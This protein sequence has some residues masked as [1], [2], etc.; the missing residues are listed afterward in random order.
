MAGGVRR[1][2]CS[3]LR[4]AAYCALRTV[5]EDGVGGGGDSG[6]DSEGVRRDR[7]KAGA[8]DY[9]WWTRRDNNTTWKEDRA[10]R[11]C[12]VG[13]VVFKGLESGA[14]AEHHFREAAWYHE[15]T[16]TS[17]RDTRHS[18]LDMLRTAIPPRPFHSHHALLTIHSR[19]ELPHH[20]IITIALSPLHYHHCITT[21]ALPPLHYHH[22]IT[23]IA[24]PPLHYYLGATRPALLRRFTPSTSRSTTKSHHYPLQ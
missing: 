1:A 16:N 18:T 14:S 7:D 10:G 20:R 5:L 23:T 11:A 6:G 13:V 2:S 24:L 17:I 15:T 8:I 21:I 12:A 9:T 3:L 19:N 22:C 4:R